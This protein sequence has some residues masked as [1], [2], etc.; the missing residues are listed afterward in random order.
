VLEQ[1]AEAAGEHALHRLLRGLA[2]APDVTGIFEYRRKRL[3]EMFGGG[4][5][6]GQRAKGSNG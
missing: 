3:V 1:V 2:Q 6:N 5:P 4:G